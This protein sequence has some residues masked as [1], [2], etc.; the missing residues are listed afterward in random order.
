MRIHHFGGLVEVLVK[1]GLLM[2]LNEFRC[3]S[4]F[5]VNSVA[6]KVW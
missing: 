1:I 6:W 2:E 3:N 4:V 5:T